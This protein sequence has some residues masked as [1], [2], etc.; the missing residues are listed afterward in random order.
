MTSEHLVV[1]L[2]VPRPGKVKTRLAAAIGGEAACSA[3]RAIVLQ[4]LANL[5]S[6]PRIELRFDP[7]DGLNE[8]RAWLQGNWKAL[9]QGD[10]DLGERLNRCFRDCF[11]KGAR[12]VVVIGSD[13]PEVGVRDV[14][15]AWSALD[16]CD[17]VLGPAQD[18]GYWLVGLRAFQPRLFEDI[19]W[20]TS[21]VLRQTTERAAES[22][23][24]ATFLRT[25]RDIDSEED[26]REFLRSSRQPAGQT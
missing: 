1:F 19:S 21:S 25:L 24:S 14:R 11:Q 12:K 23:L 3:Y 9:P 17:L 13:C 20:S 18:G 22:G 10:G 2:K 6:L 5:R 7:A 8:V 26:W 16:S 4:L 15:K